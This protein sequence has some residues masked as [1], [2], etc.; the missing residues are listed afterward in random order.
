M[1]NL[2]AIKAHIE[3]LEFQSQMAQ[4]ITMINRNE[5]NDYEN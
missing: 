5:V 2:E 1:D 3:E 4:L